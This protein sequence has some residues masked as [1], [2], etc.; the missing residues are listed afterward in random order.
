MLDFL[1]LPQDPVTDMREF[2]PS[3]LQGRYADVSDALIHVVRQG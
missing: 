3:P 1:R 2:P